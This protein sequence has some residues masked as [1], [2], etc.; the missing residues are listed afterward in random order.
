MASANAK[1]RA[2]KMM[3]VRVDRRLGDVF[4]L[5]VRR[6]I[7]A[8]TSTSGALGPTLDRDRSIV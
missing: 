4:F 2:Q 8:A 3:L 1:D 6:R 7:G 5:R